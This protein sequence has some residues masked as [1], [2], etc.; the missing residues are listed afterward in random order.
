M[1]RRRPRKNKKKDQHRDFI[2]NGKRSK[3]WARFHQQ[4]GIAG[5]QFY[6]LRSSVTPKS[7]SPVV[8]TYMK[9]ESPSKLLQASPQ[10]PTRAPPV[11]E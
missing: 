7:S 10:T 9:K 2:K 6:S 5:L 8:P 11:V 3:I 1:V 4:R